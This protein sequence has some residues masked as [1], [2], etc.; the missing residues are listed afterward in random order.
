[1]LWKIVAAVNNVITAL[2]RPIETAMKR[3]LCPARDRMNI[4]AGATRDAVRPP[5]E[6]IAENALLRQQLI[7]LRRQLRRP[8]FND[9]ARLI[10]VLRAQLEKAWSDALHRVK[11]DTRAPLAPVAPR[12][13]QADLEAE[14]ALRSGYAQTARKGHNRVDHGNGARQRDLGSRVNPC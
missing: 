11:P 9:G 13:V 5:S 3:L 4:L 10:M 8:N 12:F 7:V 2:S 6:L 14:V 1:M